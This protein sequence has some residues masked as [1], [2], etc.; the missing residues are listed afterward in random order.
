VQRE[1]VLHDEPGVP[2]S[3]LS[4]EAKRAKLWKL[5]TILLVAIGLCTGILLFSF[6]SRQNLPSKGNLEG[7]R[8]IAVLP[9]KII[10]LNNPDG[11]L[12]V[13]MADALITQ[14]GSQDRIVVRPSSAMFKYHGKDVDPMA[15]G[16]ELKVDAVLAASTQR[17]G[18]RTRLTGQLLRISDGRPIWTGKFDGETTDLFALE[19]SVSEAVAR[20]LLFR[21]TSEQEK[22]MARRYA[23]SS[24]A[25]QRYVKR[26]Y[27]L[28]RMDLKK[29]RAY[30]EQAIQR[31][32]NFAQA[33]G[34]LASTYLLDAIPAKVRRSKTVELITRALEIDQTLAEAHLSLAMVKI[35]FDLD[36]PGAKKEIQESMRLKPHFAMELNAV[37][38]YRKA[39]S[40]SGENRLLEALDDVYRRQGYKQAKR[41]V[42]KKKLSHLEKKA[43]REYVSPLSRALVCGELG[44]TSET[45][46]LLEKAHEERDWF[47]FYIKTGPEFDHLHSEPRFVALLQKMGVP[48]KVVFP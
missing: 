3:V 38:A 24:E 16:R 35:F 14:L 2:K 34:D 41:V 29:A 33:Y 43:S 7:I 13:A 32:P 11:Y 22:Q 1:Q 17:S 46:R 39:L 42:L 20:S 6:K 36:W 23:D 30:F 40:L 47:L 26:D 21:L 28:D 9:F 10:G 31:N 25:Y 12:G 15:A 37:Q 44:Y 18:K 45:L 19:D 4:A 5:L 48:A 8:S 27:F